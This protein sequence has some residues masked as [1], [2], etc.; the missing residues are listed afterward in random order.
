MPVL[1]FAENSKLKTFFV[2]GE[3]EWFLKLFLEL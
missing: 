1:A 2:W 3:F